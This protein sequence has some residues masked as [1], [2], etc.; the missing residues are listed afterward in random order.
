MQTILALLVLLGCNS[1][2]G[3]FSPEQIHIALTGVP[4]E[5]VVSWSTNKSTS[6]A[7][8]IYGLSAS[9]LTLHA[10]GDEFAFVEGNHTIHLHNVKL[11]G[12]QL[13]STYYYQ[14]GTP[15]VWSETFS[16]K[17][18]PD[19][20]PQ[21]DVAMYGDMGL[22]NERSLVPLVAEAQ[23]GTYDMVIH[24]GDMAYDLQ[25]DNGLRGDAFMRTI[26]PIS[27]N[28]PYMVC[29]GNHET[30]NFF[31][32]YSNRF[33]GITG[34]ESGSNTNWWYSFDVSYVHFIAL[35]SEVYYDV[36]LYGRVTEQYLWLEN[37]LKKAVANRDRVPWIVVFGH[38]PVY[39]SNTDD[40]PDC[41][42]DAQLLR[43]GPEGVMGFEDIFAKYNV[44]LYI[45]AH[46]HSYERSFPVFRGQIDPQQ[47]HTYINA[48]YPVYLVS[49]AAGCQEDL[50]YFDNVHYAP[51]SA[52]RSSTYGYAHLKMV[53]S[54]HLHWRQLLDEGNQGEDELWLIKTPGFKPAS[55]K[56]E[57]L[58]T[59]SG[60]CYR[61]CSMAGKANCVRDCGC[62]AEEK[63]GTLDALGRD[64]RTAW[65]RRM[66]R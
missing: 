39:C 9:N 4:G 16:F 30:A 54:T 18:F 53:N 43:R 44:D 46:E 14:C 55:V 38:R 11:S 2:L 25:S 19:G 24:V 63:T 42:T 10:T 61:V 66:K 8:V 22:Y 1:V 37:D 57:L 64:V 58:S 34:K 40:L 41:T 45:S 5:M 36:A 27:A 13:G 65:E 59:C 48:K 7:H 32:Q 26:Q 6:G 62:Q 12:L 52:F 20:Y 21:I 23:A 28:Y 31:R 50:D 60:Y 17:T 33:S 3:Q 56:T 51:Q 35:S 15:K 47:N 49:G 29:H